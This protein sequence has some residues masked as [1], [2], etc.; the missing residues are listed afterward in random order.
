[1]TDSAAR[2]VYVVLDSRREV[3]SVAGTQR[4]AEK[5]VARHASHGLDGYKI[6]SWAVRDAFAE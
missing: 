4:I 5:I 1:M 2:T 3:V 6:E